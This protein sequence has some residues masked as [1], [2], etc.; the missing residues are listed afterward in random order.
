MR[1]NKRLAMYRKSRK[2]APWLKD[3]RRDIE[4]IG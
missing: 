2:F 4:S 1:E 3:N